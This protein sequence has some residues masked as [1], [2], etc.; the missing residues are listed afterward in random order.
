MDAYE[1]HFAEPA[2]TEPGSVSTESPDLSP[3]VP[4]DPLAPPRSPRSPSLFD[5]GY[6][7]PEPGVSHA[8]PEPGLPSSPSGER[9]L[10]TT[11]PGL[12][13]PALDSASTVSFDDAFDPLKDDTSQIDQASGQWNDLLLSGLALL[14]EDDDSRE[15][16]PWAPFS[17]EAGPDVDGYAIEMR[18]EHLREQANGDSIRTG[19]REVLEVG[20]S[21]DNSD[22]V[23]G[24]D[25]V[26]ISGHLREHTGGAFAENAD[27]VSLEVDG[28]L[29]VYSHFE[30]GI[31]M[32]GT[33]TDTWEDGAVVLAAMS[34]DLAAGAGVRVSAPVDLWLHGLCGLEERPGTAYIDAVLLELAGTH[35]ER[36]YGS[37]L[38]FGAISNLSGTTVQVQATGFRPLL[39]SAIRVRN[40]VPGGGGGGGEPG[41]S[42]PPSGMSAGAGPGLAAQLPML[43]A[44]IG[45]STARTAAGGI[46]LDDTLAM[47]RLGEMA[48]DVEDLSSLRRS[49]DTAADLDA[50]S[51]ARRTG[52]AA[53]DAGPEPGVGTARLLDQG[54][55]ALE[56]TDVLRLDPPGDS[57]G[58]DP[59]VRVLDGLESQ[60][61]LVEPSG[62]VP[63]EPYA[64]SGVYSNPRVE[65]PSG[66]APVSLV[67]ET[68]QSTPLSLTPAPRPDSFD[69]ADTYQELARRFVATGN[70]E[71]WR[72]AQSYASALQTLRAHTIDTF[73]TFGGR[74]EDLSPG[75]LDQVGD[76]YRRLAA[77]ASEA[78]AAGDTARASPIRQ[79]VEELDELAHGYVIDL[80]PAADELAS[81]AVAAPASLLDDSGRHATEPG[82]SVSDAGRIEADADDGGGFD[83]G[84]LPA[85]PEDAPSTARLADP[86]DADDARFRN[87][88]DPGVEPPRA[89]ESGAGSARTADLS[90]SGG[91]EPLTP[92]VDDDALSW[93]RG[94][95]DPPTVEWDAGGNV[96]GGRASSD[97][98]SVEAIADARAVD[99]AVPEPGTMVAGDAAR[100]LDQVDESADASEDIG[101]RLGSAGDTG[102]PPSSEVELREDMDFG[103][104]PEDDGPSWVKDNYEV[105]RQL[106]AGN[107][108]EDFDSGR[109]TRRWRKR[110]KRMRG[111]ESSAPQIKL[112][113]EIDGFFA[114]LQR[115]EL[116][117]QDVMDAIAAYKARPDAAQHTGAVR[118]LENVLGE[119]DQ[120]LNRQYGYRANPDWVSDVNKGLD[121]RQA[122]AEADE[123]LRAEDAVWQ[124]YQDLAPDPLTR[125]GAG[126]D[127]AVPTRGASASDGSPA[128]L[129]SVSPPE[130][131]SESVLYSNGS[132]PSLI[133]SF[134]RAPP[135]VPPRPDFTLRS[136]DDVAGEA[137]SLEDLRHG[138]SGTGSGAGARPAS[139]SDDPLQDTPFHQS[140]FDVNRLDG[141]DATGFRD[142]GIADT[143]TQALKPKDRRDFAYVYD[144]DDLVSLEYGVPDEM[145]LN[146]R[147]VDAKQN[148]KL[149]PSGQVGRYAEIL[150]DKAGTEAGQ[151][152][153]DS[154][155]GRPNLNAMNRVS[156]DAAKKARLEAINTKW[157]ELPEL[158]VRSLDD[159]GDTAPG[160]RAKVP[161]RKVGFGDVQSVTFRVETSGDVSKKG[162]PLR[163]A[164][165]PASV[166]DLDTTLRYSLDPTTNAKIVTT[167]EGWQAKRTPGFGRMTSASGD[168][169]FSQRE[170]MLKKL[171]GGTILSSHQ[172]DV[173][174]NEL[175]TR[176]PIND[177]S[178]TT[179]QYQA[180]D[181]ML[182]SLYTKHR[183]GGSRL[184]SNVNW[185]ALY[186]LA[187]LMD[188]SAAVA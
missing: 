90:G 22:V 153:L 73:T 110:L 141:Y 84:R 113:D 65:E 158:N 97:V 53:G 172:L 119:L 67:D 54:E 9:G 159:L 44:G 31:M 52:E 15:P 173:L 18:A 86:S 30:D 4:D 20:A 93:R 150:A 14:D 176:F 3:F 149:Q 145:V 163:A 136:A 50:L 38:Q 27:D 47:A 28:R 186:D 51:D 94:E 81:P 151:H 161:R 101:A 45:A 133:G 174:S 95:G 184:P 105:E 156:D 23:A 71:D 98:S 180:M 40:L 85:D 146:R 157:K 102:A 130:P 6:G 19:E 118:I 29:D 134:D 82:A 70:S 178:R 147:N 57:G 33:L 66:D 138:D 187:R 121:L 56:G 61:P 25:R 69:F 10:S 24:V 126:D 37:S 127:G 165:D 140:S 88:L 167:P 41:V 34:D 48:A 36:E 58:A 175:Y 16:A 131:G 120:A 26:R 116:P 114:K 80:A 79:A 83:V 177:P 162:K 112:A 78:E 139:L 13:D 160:V 129:H 108:P 182:G 5:S 185:D 89:G 64:F 91:S 87:S 77:L 39:K 96:R 117:R 43:A 32:A 35:F 115:R 76:A 74:V 8:H 164:V 17:A 1:L 75:V 132:N 143:E 92:V 99:D 124:R 60:D 7:S 12:S 128:A 106:A 179:A 72:S 168:F 137:A 107:L 49:A 109:V 100:P 68:A 122:D 63:E 2:S 55:P 42:P 183:I 59:G 154:H 152:Y 181:R 11:S 166:I 142:R 169:P 123:I 188:S 155:R 170:Q 171:M 21:E 46:R 62:A 111:A 103:F 135:P 148:A 104:D 125:P 144:G